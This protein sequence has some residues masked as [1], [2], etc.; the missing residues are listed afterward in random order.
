M[1]TEIHQVT[2]NLMPAT[3]TMAQAFLCDTQRSCEPL[4]SSTPETAPL[5]PESPQMDYQCSLRNSG[6]VLTTKIVPWPCGGD[7]R[8]FKRLGDPKPAAF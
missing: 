8:P 6:P 7:R 4:Q 1:G 2:R 3:S 5:P